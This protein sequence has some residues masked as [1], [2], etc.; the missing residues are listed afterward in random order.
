MSIKEFIFIFTTIISVLLLFAQEKIVP[1]PIDS[2]I[3]AARERIENN[4]TEAAQNIYKQILKIDKNSL[5]A[6]VTLGEIAVAQKK[7]GNAKEYFER[8]IKIEPDNLFA[9]YYLGI[10]FRETGKFKAFLFRRRDW[11]KSNRFFVTVFTKDSLFQDVYYQYAKLLR[12][13]KKYQEAVIAGHKQIDLRPDLIEPKVKLFRLYLYL[14]S[15]SDNE[16]TINWL[17]NQPWDHSKYFKGEI[18]RRKGKIVK[19]DSV[20]QNMIQQKLNIPL[21]PLYLSLARIKYRQNLPKAGEK[22]FWLALT[23][24]KTSVDANLVFKEIK[25]IV[26]EEE[27]HEYK[28]LKDVKDKVEYFQNFWMSRDPIPASSYNVP[29]R[30]NY[31][32]WNYHKLLY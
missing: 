15:N 22:F 8:I 28:A 9:N 14:I 32:N 19:A 16:E 4:E 27:L 3:E 18:Y 1:Q 7:W 29:I 20:F 24:V 17:E 13:R 23:K 5:P 30:I 12:Y 31:I 10:C 11:D 2:L 25:Y 6:L 26:T 21:P